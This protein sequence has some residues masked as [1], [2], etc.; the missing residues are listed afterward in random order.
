MRFPF[1]SRAR[2]LAAP[3][4]LAALT[5]SCG[6]ASQVQNAAA[7][8][9]APDSALMLQAGN[10][11]KGGADNFFLYQTFSDQQIEFAPGDVLSYDIYLDPKN[12]LPR[13]GIDIEMGEGKS[14]RDSGVVD[15]NGLRAHGDQDL[16]VASGQW[17]H[18]EFPMDELAGKRSVH[19]MLQNEGNAEGVYTQFIDNVVVRRKDGSQIAIYASGAP[20]VSNTQMKSGY[21]QNAVLMAVP[22][23]ELDATRDLTAFIGAQV[24]REN[25]IQHL[26]DLRVRVAIARAFAERTRDDATLARMTEAARVLAPFD[27]DD[28]NGD[29]LNVASRQV[30]TLLGAA[31]VASREYAG[32]LAGHAHLDFQWQWPWSESIQVAHDTFNQA[33]KFM[34]E[35]PGFSFD[36][37]S[38]ALYEAV[39][40]NH[41]DI[42]KGIQKRVAAG[43]WDIVGGR[44]CEGDTNLISPESHARHFLIAQRYFRA[45]FGKTAVVGW[46]PDTFGHTAQMPQIEKLGGCQYYYFCRAGGSEPFFWWQAL[47]GT[48]VLAFNEVAANAWYNND[49]T[50]KFFDKLL[51]FQKTTGSKEMLWV[52]GVGNHGGGPTREH[53]ETARKWQNTPAFPQAKFAGATRFFTDVTKQDLT[54]LP[55]VKRDLN[56]T[57]EGCYTSHSDVKRWNRDAESLTTSAETIAAFAAQY[58]FAYPADELRQNWKDITWNHHHDTICGTAIESSYDFSEKMYQ[59]IFASSKSIGQRALLHIA[60]R[61]TGKGN[62]I[63]VFNPVGWQRSGIVEID[64]PKGREYSQQNIPL[65]VVSNDDSVLA[66]RVPGTKN[67]AIFYARNLPA[68]GYRRYR[69][70]SSFNILSV[71]TKAQL[72]N[73]GAVL[74]NAFYRVTLDNRGL[75][76]SIFDKRRKV[77]TL[78]KGGTGNRLEV[79]YEA[80]ADAWTIGN[81]SRVETLDAPVKMEISES[82]PARASVR[83]TRRFASSDLVQTVSLSQ[84]G[85]PEFSLDTK[86]N[87]LGAPDKPCP[88]L[89]VAFDVAAQNPSQTYDV[90]FGTVSRAA[91][92]KEYPALKW[93]DLSGGDGGAALLNDC[94]HGYS[95]KGNTLYLSLIRSSYSPDP[96]PNKRPQ[97]ARWSFLPH[98]G[99]WRSAGVLQAA[100]NFNAPLWAANAA[101]VARGSLAPQ[102]SFLSSGS[103]DVVITGVKQ[104]EDDRDLIV[105]FYEAYGTPSRAALQL[106]FDVTRA[107]SVNFVED[108]LPDTGGLSPQLRSYEIKTLKLALRRPNAR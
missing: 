27:N 102:G 68:F 36:Q 20:Q 16:S 25:Q 96:V 74:D 24:E 78:R 2:V 19:W 43:T 67:R 87:E 6:V 8:N 11:S 64:L 103:R 22:R 21:S 95:A 77:E 84:S 56:T 26:K 105:R 63:V 35:Y 41:P 32:Y 101:P 10:I 42:F 54:K 4:A 59:R 73:G 9:T 46:E 75:A 55:V 62:G 66:Q 100:N 85:A 13:G 33:L 40:I 65:G 70:T 97:F 12:P 15:Q 60:A 58:G 80:P 53:L 98:A 81:I 89:K 17:Y 107:Q 93:V 18:R 1:R 94:K 88:F 47:D 83:W 31:S 30:E 82:G 45:R 51:D 92:G 71:S 108:K 99:S 14:L 3:I 37:S 106:P 38:S 57:F 28:W 76:T 29:A 69:I 44:V 61:V 86:W 48:R 7:Q 91:D 49:V 50:Y 5:I 104:A 34:D 23:A 39:E 72:Q 90:P 52:Y 79:S